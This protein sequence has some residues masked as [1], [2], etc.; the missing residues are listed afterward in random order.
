MIRRRKPQV[1]A[2]HDPIPHIDIEASPSLH[3]FFHLFR[4][5]GVA[6]DDDIKPLHEFSV[7]KGPKGRRYPSGTCGMVSLVT[8]AAHTDGRCARVRRGPI[9]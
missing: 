5:V 3:L 7:R 1:G 6:Q 8:L 9:Q 2:M 4:K